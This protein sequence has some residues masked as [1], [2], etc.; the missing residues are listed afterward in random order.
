MAIDYTFHKGET[1]SQYHERLAREF[2]KV[3]K[4]YYG[5]GKKYADLSRSLI[6]PSKTTITPKTTNTGRTTKTTTPTTPRVFTTPRTPTTSSSGGGYTPPAPSSKP[7]A[8]SGQSHQNL[9]DLSKTLAGGQ[10]SQNTDYKIYYAGHWYPKNQLE[11]VNG[12]WQ[13]RTGGSTDNTEGVVPIQ[14]ENDVH[15]VVN[16][17][18]ST[19][20]NNQNKNQ[21][22]SQLQ[23]ILNAFYNSK[24][25]ETKSGEVTTRF[26]TPF[27]MPTMPSRVD[28]VKEYEDFRN[29][30]QV[31][32]LEAQLSQVDKQIADLQGSYD[33]TITKQE[34]RLA[35][36][37]AITDMEKKIGRDYIDRLNAL[38]REK[39]VLVNQLNMKYDTINTLMKLSR[40]SYLD[41][42]GQYDRKYKE[43]Q[44][45]YNMFYKERAYEDTQEERL[46][47]DA[48]ANLGVVTDTLT[49]AV[50]NGS[51]TSL[52]D[53]DDTTKLQIRKLE[54]QAGL[55]AGFIDKVIEVAKPI[56]ESGGKVIKTVAND[57]GSVVSVLIQEPDGSI[58]VKK[59]NTG[60]VKQS[61]T[62]EGQTKPF[63]NKTD[64]QYFA[65]HEIP[66]D[67]AD[68]ISTALQLGLSLEA[69]RRALAEEYGKDKGYHYLDLVIPYLQ[70]KTNNSENTNF[71]FGE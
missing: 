40:E 9:V 8:P 47:K 19:L 31:E 41:S 22:Q 43:Y 54:T 51:I 64:Y 50:K 11:F 13:F 33:T 49:D 25:A 36:R 32:P 62:K 23:D 5:G 57:D 28:Y 61:K 70:S 17:M 66:R 15:D 44:D 55:P 46:K 6:T 35:S 52:K 20:D 56:T 34:G 39:Q 27:Q 29:K 24:L 21:V 69:I 67:V 48:L 4:V 63:W 68:T 18:K 59:I 37:G 7:P 30:Y 60:V 16:K 71:G 65:S 42:L 26:K 10:P 12:Q 1:I 58:G 45:L 3:G 38:N 14:T 53:L 2:A